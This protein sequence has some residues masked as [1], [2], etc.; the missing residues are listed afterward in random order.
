[1][2]DATALSERIARRELSCVEVMRDHL[3]RIE[4]GNPALNAIVSLRDGDALLAEAAARARSC[5]STATSSERPA[6]SQ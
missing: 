1:M 3:E 2:D 6:S 5:T 4:R